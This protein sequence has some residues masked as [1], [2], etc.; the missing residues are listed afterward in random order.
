MILNGNKRMALISLKTTS[1]VKPIILKGR[2]INHISGSKKIKASAN[3]Q[4]NTNKINHKITAII[5]FI[6]K[7]VSTVF[8]NS[9]PI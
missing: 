6:E 9:E 5:V 2:R 3:G 1:S 7:S 4:H 8:A